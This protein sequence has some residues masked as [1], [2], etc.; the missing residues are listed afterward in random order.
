MGVSIPLKIQFHAFW[1]Y[2]LKYFEPK[3]RSIMKVDSEAR[4]GF[5]RF[6]E[7]RTSRIESIPQRQNFYCLKAM[8]TRRLTTGI[9]SEKMRR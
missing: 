4:G 2:C 3:W 7:S 1:G 9:R 6:N 8:I 5:I